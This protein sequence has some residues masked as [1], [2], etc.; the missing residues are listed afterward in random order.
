MCA[1]A[2]VW[3]V[4]ERGED[5]CGLVV[6]VATTCSDEHLSCSDEHL[7]TDG[8][9]ATGLH[10]RDGTRCEGSLSVDDWCPTIMSC[11]GVF[12][13]S[14]PSRSAETPPD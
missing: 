2:A 11:G 6:V 7:C 10:A 12:S 14:V 8:V 3:L 9:A 1:V 4:W 13:T 5:G